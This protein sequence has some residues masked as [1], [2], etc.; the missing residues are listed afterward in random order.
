MHAPEPWTCLRAEEPDYYIGLI[1]SPAGHVTSIANWGAFGK[2]CS[3]SEANARLI[4]QAPALMRVL[5]RL[6]QWSQ[7]TGGWDAEC[8]QEAETLLA[9]LQSAQ[10]APETDE[11]GPEFA[12]HARRAGAR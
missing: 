8:W 6:V 11:D 12:P 7:L 5:K 3:T 10:Q 4:C 1:N 2:T 9:E